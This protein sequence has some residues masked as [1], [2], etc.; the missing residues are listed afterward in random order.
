MGESSSREQEQ[1]PAIPPRKLPPD[2]V[3][4]TWEAL[5]PWYQELEER[6]LETVQDLEN[7]LLDRSEV[8]AAVSAVSARLNVA[9]VRHT[10]DEDAERAHLE[11]Q[12]EVIPPVRKAGDRLDHKYLECPS[13]NSLDEGRWG[14]Y[15]RDCSLSAKLFRE[16][17][18]ALGVDEEECIIEYG[19]LTGSMTVEWEGETLTL[20]ALAKYSEV[21]DRAVRE[22]AWR[23]ASQRR[24]EDREALEDLFD[25]MRVLREKM[26]ANADFPDFRAF[27]HLEYGRLDYEPADCMV[28][29][30]SIEDHVGPLLARMQATR[31]DSFGL[32]HLRP[33]DMAADPLGR[34]AFEPFKDPSGQ[35]RVAASLLEKVAPS[36]ADD[37]RWMEAEGL[38]DLETRPHK[39][40]GGFME[41][42]EDRR[43][44]FIFANSGTT[45]RD[46]ETLVHEGGHAAHALLSRE[47]E[48]GSYRHAPLEFAEVA[49]MGMECMTM[50]HLDA[51]YPAE[52]AGRARRF[53]LE[54]V[55]SGLAW[56]ATVD[57]FQHWI[58]THP[59]HTREERT[60]EWLALRCRFSSGVNWEGLEKEHAFEWHR[61][62]HIFEVP[63]YYVEYALAQMGA[64]QVWSAY[65]KNPE[66]AVAAYRAGLSLGGCRPLPALFEAAGLRFDPRGD[67]LPSLMAEVEE[68]WGLTL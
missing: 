3:A 16:E 2:W 50:E 38:L 65:R 20:P 21:A 23:L 8:D 59:S 52:E 14:V 42:F 4:S 30:Q 68:A 26:A 11:Y 67:L 49:S 31:K 32:D 48:P 62:L 40:Q 66:A 17:N 56:I 1:Y 19:H 25:K 15:D 24:L 5:E 29:H 7:W 36:F 41:T 46:V 47:L 39:R 28:L 13:R 55:V 12:T 34:P 43:V 64:L 10:D 57:A 27:R 44:P 53:A 61:Q 45:H 54:G 51:V 33:W 60:E 9:H 18:V 35:V 63:F 6:P 22:K 37:L 58:Y